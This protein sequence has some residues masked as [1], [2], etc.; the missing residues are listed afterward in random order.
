MDR[1]GGFFK[2]IVLLSLELNP[3]LSKAIL[4]SIFVGGKIKIIKIIVITIHQY[5]PVRVQDNPDPVS[6]S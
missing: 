4:R 1:C 6:L 5:I 2:K 3:D